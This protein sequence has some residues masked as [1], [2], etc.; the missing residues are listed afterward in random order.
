MPSD[1]QTVQP[2][3]QATTPIEPLKSAGHFQSLQPEQNPSRNPTGQSQTPPLPGKEEKQGWFRSFSRN[4]RSSALTSLHPSQDQVIVGSIR[5]GSKQ[6]DEVKDLAKPSE[7]EG[8]AGFGAPVQ[9]AEEIK[10]KED[11]RKQVETGKSLSTSASPN[12]PLAEGEVRPDVSSLSNSNIPSYTVELA[13][14]STSPSSTVTHAQ[15][16]SQQ[17]KTVHPQQSMASLRGFRDYLGWTGSNA[18]GREISS[19][20]GDTRVRRAIRGRMMNRKPALKMVRFILPYYAFTQ[21]LVQSFKPLKK[22]VHQHSLQ[23]LQ[24]PSHPPPKVNRVPGHPTCI[25]LSFPNQNKVRHKVR[26]EL[27]TLLRARIILQLQCL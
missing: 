23:K 2:S 9:S 25:H 7:I 15:G 17:K 5:H 18:E 1:S 16:Q 22:H 27:V 14:E 4:P 19:K 21:F 10:T 11:T 13:A 6:G 24:K 20:K 8:S 3:Q 26:K 12:P